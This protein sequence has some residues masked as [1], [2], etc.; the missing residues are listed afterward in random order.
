M[1]RFSR[2]DEVR[3]DMP[4]VTDR[5]FEHFHDAEGTIIEV[6]EDDADA[7]TGD[8][9]NKYVFRVMLRDGR[10]VDVRWRDLRPI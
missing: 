6:I 4:D 3:I 9:R 2:G 5:D 1:K 10:E 7:V 8:V